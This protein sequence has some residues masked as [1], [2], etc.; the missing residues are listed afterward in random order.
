MHRPTPYGPLRIAASGDVI[1]GD[2][3]RHAI[4]IRLGGG[5]RYT[6]TPPCIGHVRGSRPF[7]RIE[8]HERKFFARWTNGPLS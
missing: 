4:D 6:G 3:E 1:V 2:L 5:Q 7:P 8:R